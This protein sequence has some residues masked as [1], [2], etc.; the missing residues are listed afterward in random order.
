M[1]GGGGGEQTEEEGV[2][3]CIYP[4]TYTY[5]LIHTLASH[6][7]PPH[8][9]SSLPFSPPLPT[10]SLYFS[11]SSF[12]L[13]SS[14]YHSQDTHSHSSWSETS[15]SYH[16]RTDESWHKKEHSHDSTEEEAEEEPDYGEGKVVGSVGPGGNN[17]DWCWGWLCAYHN[18]ILE[19]GG[20]VWEGGRGRV[21]ET[22]QFAVIHCLLL[23][24]ICFGSQLC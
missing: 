11:L 5:W 19:D 4:F 3:S 13:L 2:K 24:Q 14:P 8:P 23:L 12:P 17:C 9:S 16:N 1:C 22:I 20:C 15:A 21:G 6:L 18:H 10:P 7:L